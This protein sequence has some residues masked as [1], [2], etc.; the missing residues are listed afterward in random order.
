MPVLTPS[1]EDVRIYEVAILYPFPMNQKEENQMLKDITALFEE[2]G[3]KLMEQDKWG[4]RG[5]G[6]KIGGHTEGVFII[7]YY[8]MDPAK[9]KG[10]DE[11]LR[12]IPGVLRHLIVKPP[13]G[14]VVT[15]YSE[16][17]KNWLKDR[18]SQDDRK[19]RETE[20]ALQKKVSD[21]AKRQVKRVQEEKAEKVAENAKPMVKKELDKE[22]EK[23]IS[24]DELEL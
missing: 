11:A 10:V 13:K 23:L 8:E 15:K 20:E 1:S 21:K 24:D 17:Y 18:E 3:A 22:L 2:S 19:S 4:Q 14:Y 16:N 5:L 7:S 12:I 6:Y 9:L